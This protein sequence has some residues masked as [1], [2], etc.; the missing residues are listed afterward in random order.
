MGKMIN[1]VVEVLRDE[2]GIVSVSKCNLGVWNWLSYVWCDDVN[3][4]MGEVKDVD[5]DSIDV[6]GEEL[7]KLYEEKLVELFDGFEE[8]EKDDEDGV[9]W[10]KVRSKFLKMVKDVV[11]DEVD[12]LS[13][14]KVGGFS[15]EYDNS[16][17]VIIGKSEY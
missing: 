16:I 14:F 3:N 10:V 15:V 12:N 1:Y 7:W 13:L 8:E 11:G 2:D 5:I 17:C 9:D 6:Y 4:S